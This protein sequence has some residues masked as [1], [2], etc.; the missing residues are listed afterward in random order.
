[1]A[2][3]AAPGR[4]TAS[5][6]IRGRRLR[7]APRRPC[8][9][10]TSKPPPAA[11]G[12][13]SLADYAADLEEEIAGAGSSRRSWSAIRWAGLLAQ[14]LAAR[15]VAR[16]LCWRRPRPGACRL[17]PCSRSAP[18]RRCCCRWASGTRCW[19]PLRYR[20]GPFAGPLPRELRDEVY[21]RLGA[22]IGPRHLR[23]DALGPG[24]EPR[25]RS[26]C[27]KVTA[28]LL[29]LAGSEDRINPPGRWSASPRSMATARPSKSCPA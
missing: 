11:L 6:E 15:E 23:D 17:P 1:M 18:P 4:W 25:Q 22:G 13:T 9:F 5:A 16:A 27:R 26:G 2:A 3:F 29:F 20:A 12:T 21:D 28:P 8:A 7:R 14:M 10:T 19:S 24:H